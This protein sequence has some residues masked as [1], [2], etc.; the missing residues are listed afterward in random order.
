[1]NSIVGLVLII[2]GLSVAAVGIFT[3]AALVIY[4]VAA[5]FVGIFLEEGGIGDPVGHVPR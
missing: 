4:G 1:M 2:A 5:F 3:N